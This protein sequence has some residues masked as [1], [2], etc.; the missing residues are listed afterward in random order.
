M[1]NIISIT[2]ILIGVMVALF[3]FQSNA[4]EASASNTYQIYLPMV[5]N[6]S[7][8]ASGGNLPNPTSEPLTATPVTPTETP[9]MPTAT[10]YPGEPT[11]K[12]EEPTPTATLTPVPPTATSTPV[13]PTPTNTPVTPTATP[14]TVSGNSFY[15]APN[16]S[17]SGDGSVNRPW[18]LQTALDHPSRVQAGDTIWLR[19]GNYIGQFTVHLKGSQGKPIVVRQYPGERAILQET[20]LIL[21][22]QDT[23]YVDF[24]GFEMKSNNNPRDPETRPLWGFGVRVYQ[25]LSSHHVR[26]INMIIHDMPAQGF[27][28]WI[29][30]VDAEI[31]G[32]L[33]YHNG[34]TELDHGIYT[35]NQ[36]GTKVIEDNYIFDNA[37]H[38]VHAYSSTDDTLNN[39]R[40]EG[41]TIFNNGSIGYNTVTGAYG[42]YKR[43]ILVGGYVPANNPVI[44]ENY[45]YYPGGSGQ[46]LN[47][48]YIEGST[49]AVI[50]GNYLMGGQVQLGGT[51]SN[52]SMRE[53]TIYSSSLYGFSS[54]QFPNNTYTS[55][56]PNGTKVFVRP[57]KYEENRANITIYNW[58]MK[59]TI[60]LTASDLAEFGIPTGAT[61]EIRNV[62]DY[63]GDIITGIYNGSSITIPMTGHSVAQPLG[64]GFKPATTF[65]EFGG[66]VIIYTA[67]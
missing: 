30:N 52:V 51:Y 6:G 60:T 14:I 46:S 28:W 23:W 24:W 15:V 42:T 49:N 12:P 43:N 3:G 11:P 55:S 1:K 39:F 63:F 35:K 10:S 32:S 67:P 57:N 19:G 4:I 7:E 29:A 54:S 40:V 64:L 8:N 21:D 9:V 17:P 48:G 26:F 18:D 33:I 31:Y 36:T 47:V 37:S 56:K 61:Y 38:G 50:E 58:D 5:L 25:G 62:Q 13:T 22:I 45:T 2:V 66:F 53:N 59:S 27:G 44:K 41:N 16:G 65:P 20:G 34:V